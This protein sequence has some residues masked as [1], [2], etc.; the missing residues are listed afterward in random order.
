MA[1]SHLQPSLTLLLFELILCHENRFHQL[2]D[3][4]LDRHKEFPCVS[5]EKI[6]IIIQKTHI[7]VSNMMWTSL[8]PPVNDW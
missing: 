2:S 1:K 7:S 4:R 5:A 8:P 6:E 3:R